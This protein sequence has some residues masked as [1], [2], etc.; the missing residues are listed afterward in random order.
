MPNVTDAFAETSVDQLKVIISNISCYSSVKAVVLSEEC[1][2]FSIIQ[3][4]LFCL[5]DVLDGYFIPVEMG[6]VILW[7]HWPN[8]LQHP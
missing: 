6:K 3:L 5:S 8:S 1:G 7:D 4:G 2:S